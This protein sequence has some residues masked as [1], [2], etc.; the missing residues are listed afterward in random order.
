M[1]NDLFYKI[2]IL[3][4]LFAIKLTNEPTRRAL[5]GWNTGLVSFQEKAKDQKCYGTTIRS[6]AE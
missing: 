4:V 1:Q 6:F 5:R 3:T 2:F